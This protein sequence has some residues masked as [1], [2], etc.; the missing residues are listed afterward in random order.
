LNKAQ[1]IRTEHPFSSK[2]AIG[3]LKDD[4]LLLQNPN[5]KISL[6]WVDY[7]AQVKLDKKL[8]RRETLHF[9]DGDPTNTHVSNLV[10]CKLANAKKDN[11]K[12]IIK[13][14]VKPTVKR[15]RTPPPVSKE[16]LIKDYRILTII[17]LGEKYKIVRNTIYN[18]LKYYNIPL[19]APL[20]QP[21]NKPSKEELE[22]L[23]LTS[24][25]PDLVNHFNVSPVTI[26]SWI[27]HYKI[28]MYRQYALGEAARHGS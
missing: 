8:S 20:K 19:K 17:Q 21:S 7:L 26:Y 2:F 11:T 9:I 12:T 10:I 14:E 5:E 3:I 22:Q 28:N 23:L 6:R 27:R 16:E 25:V 18:W 24:K 4:R 1:I 13:S 15:N